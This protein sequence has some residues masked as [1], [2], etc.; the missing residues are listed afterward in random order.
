MPP[1]IALLKLTTTNT[2]LKMYE[3]KH[4]VQ[5]M[6]VPLSNLGDSLKVRSARVSVAAFDCFT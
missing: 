5:D 3:T 6:L 4:V 1:K 2:V